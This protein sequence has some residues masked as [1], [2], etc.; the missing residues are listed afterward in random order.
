MTT[1]ERDPTSHDWREAGEAWGHAAVDW[2]CLYEHY[3]TEVL[4]AMCAAIGV[5]PGVDLLD[6]ACGSG[7]AIRFATGCGAT[8]AGIDAAD[9]LLAIARERNPDADIR[10]GSMFELPWPDASFDA[11]MSVNGIWGDCDDA[12]REMRRVIRPGG[13]VG[14][15]FWGDGKDGS[16]LDMR[17]MFVALTALTP[18]T[19]V[20]GMR[21]TNRIAKPG[22]AEEMLTAAG[23]EVIERGS[24]VSVM[25]WPDE[26]IVWRAISSCGPLVPAQQHSGEAVVRRDVLAALAPCRSASG[27]Y[28]YR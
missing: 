7:M 5:G 23:F 6:V 26:D 14:I 24:R 9:A 11:V 10:L 4:A 3:A 16:P 13:R 25:E 21:K 2:A 22:V 27:V 12:L 17:P 28:R 8:V 15:S 20:D 18:P 1:T 19:G